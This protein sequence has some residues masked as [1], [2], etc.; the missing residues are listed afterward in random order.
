MGPPLH[1]AARF[2]G[3]RTALAQRLGAYNN[4]RGM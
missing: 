1:Q 4:G 2:K 3:T